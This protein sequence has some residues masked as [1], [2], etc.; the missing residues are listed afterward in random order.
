M[1]DDRLNRTLRIAPRDLEALLDMAD[2][3]SASRT[4]ESKRRSRRW[5]LRSTG[6]VLT[7]Q[8]Q[9]GGRRHFLVA[10]RNLSSTG[11]G[12]IHGGFIHIG[13]TCIITMR[14]RAGVTR[15]IPGTIVKCRFMRGNLHDT[16]I[17]FGQAINPMDFVEPMGDLAFNV[18]RVDPATLT[19]RVLIVDDDRTMQKLLAHYLK[20]TRLEANYATDYETAIQC[21]KDDPDIAFIDI[22][23]PGKDGIELISAARAQHNMAPMLALTAH[24]PDEMRS[25]FL[26]AGGSGYLTKPI[27]KEL[28]LQAI[29][30]HLSAR[31]PTASG[32][33]LHST[34]AA[35]GAESELV[36]AYIEELR[37]CA[38]SLAT[39]IEQRDIQALQRVI[40]KLRGT[41]AG[42]GF[43]PITPIA[44]AA[45][46][47]L[48]ATQSADESMR[49]LQTLI[50][51]CH[52]AR[53][54]RTEEIEL[55]AD[56]AGTP[57]KAAGAKSA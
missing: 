34:L 24:A 21:L 17:E 35:S 8:A 47:S 48:K 33:L 16:G 44:D 57:E 54:S 56:S 27:T 53:P 38:D 10:P 41:A 9:A 2:Q 19:G 6:V 32:G 31:S 1:S 7:L 5:T 46:A 49:E 20:P 3:S 37:T 52:R 15:S 11:M 25:R 43:D 14:T 18:E 4:G 29:A 36:L 55:S 30:E 45:L 13:T 42:H 28:F 40:M 22:D 26:D 39:H 50:A 12:V 51:A 23:L